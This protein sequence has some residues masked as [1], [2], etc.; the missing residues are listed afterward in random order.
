M[1]GLSVLRVQR[2][3]RTAV[4][5]FRNAAGP[6]T[7]GCHIRQLQQ[8]KLPCRCPHTI[9]YKDI[10]SS[11]Q[12][13]RAGESEPAHCGHIVAPV[14]IC[15]AEAMRDMREAGV[16]IVRV[17]CRE[18]YPAPQKTLLQSRFKSRHVFASWHRRQQPCAANAISMYA[19][20]SH[21]CSDLQLAPSL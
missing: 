8:L 3:T 5:S 16:R 2:S 17:R 4:G 12:G 18:L 15:E 11:L 9:L 21:I 6:N 1:P 14:A 20:M 10:H 7:A 19:M 13:Q